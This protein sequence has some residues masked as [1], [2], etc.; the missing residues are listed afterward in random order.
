MAYYNT[1]QETGNTLKGSWKKT[2][3]QE[4]LIL[5]F[6]QRNHGLSFSPEIINK[7]VLPAVPLTSVRRAIT[8]LTN[9]GRLRKTSVMVKGKYGKK[10]HTW[11]AVVTEEQLRIF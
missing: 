2:D 10:I 3:R 7:R 11:M 9:D 5:E 4:D 1:N 8:N 6:F